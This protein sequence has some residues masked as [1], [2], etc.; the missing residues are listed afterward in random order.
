LSVVTGAFFE[1]VT[2]TGTNT[3]FASDA[4]G[5]AVS[6][7]GHMAYTRPANKTT[8]AV[9]TLRVRMILLRFEIGAGCN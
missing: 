9:T 6:I 7:A 8:K 3:V 1:S 5:A 2:F 4:C